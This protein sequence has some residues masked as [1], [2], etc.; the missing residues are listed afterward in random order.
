MWNCFDFKKAFPEKDGKIIVLF[1]VTIFSSKFNK[2]FPIFLFL[3]FMLNI[4][5]H[6][7]EYKTMA[8]SSLRITSLKALVISVLVIL[9]FNSI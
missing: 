4:K 7:P 1:F 5:D 6:R 3:N 8:L 9:L 2:D